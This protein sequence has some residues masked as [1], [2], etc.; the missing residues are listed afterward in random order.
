MADESETSSGVIQRV[1]V[2]NGWA[3]KSDRTHLLTTLS[4]ADYLSLAA[5]FVAWVGALL[6][7]SSEPNWGILTIFVAFGF[8]KLDGYWARRQGTTSSFGR[9]IDSF[10][11]VFAYLVPGALLFHYQLAPNEVVS[12]VVGFLVLAF[13]GL[14]LVRHNAAGSESHEAMSYYPGTTVVHTCMILL[15]NY[16]AINVINVWNGWIAT[17][18]VLLAAP[19]MISKYRTPK[20]ATSHVVLGV[21][22]LTI[23]FACLG[24][25]F[26]YL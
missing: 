11:D 17:G 16:V 10:I 20:T 4:T 2:R 6:F 7:L 5:L 1:A 24:I 21:L 14:R 12:A 18:T 19:L 26:G 25:E 8:D 23:G 22:M 9:Q 3:Q 13:G 15:A